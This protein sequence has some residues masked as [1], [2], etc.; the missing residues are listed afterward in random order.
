MWFLR[1]SL[2]HKTIFVLA[3]KFFF[4]Q[5][6]RG[7]VRFIGM[8]MSMNLLM[9]FV[10]KFCCQYF[11]SLLSPYKFHSIGGVVLHLAVSLLIA[12]LERVTIKDGNEVD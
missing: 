9:D 4:Y 2:R 6:L 5:Y 7:I 8:R 12:Q 11:F 10:K 1:K 3:F